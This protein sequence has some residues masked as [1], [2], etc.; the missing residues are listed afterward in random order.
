MGSAPG[1]PQD[2][3]LQEDPI[4]PTPGPNSPIDSGV[5]GALLQDGKESS[6]ET[7]PDPNFTGRSLIFGGQFPA[8]SKPQP[9]LPTPTLMQKLFLHWVLPGPALWVVGW[10]FPAAVELGSI[11]GAFLGGQLHPAARGGGQVR[12]QVQ[13]LTDFWPLISLYIGP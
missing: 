11:C 6:Y 10:G 4:C 13:A 3:S 12:I 8:V 7:R 2:S 5:V 9:H 1:A